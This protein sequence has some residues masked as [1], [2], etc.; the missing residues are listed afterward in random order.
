MKNW[1]CDEI[2]RVFLF[3]VEKTQKLTS[4]L[5]GQMLLNVGAE[6]VRR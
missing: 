4:R 6:G 5:H 3:H 2:V 1:W